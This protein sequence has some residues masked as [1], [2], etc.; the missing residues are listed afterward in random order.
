MPGDSGRGVLSPPGYSSRVR[1]PAVLPRRRGRA[2]RLVPP[3]LAGSSAGHRAEA[4][5]RCAGGRG[6]GRVALGIPQLGH[7]TCK[8]G[9]LRDEQHRRALVL[10]ARRCREGEQPGG[11]PQA[12]PRGC[13]P[14]NAPVPMAGGTGIAICRLPEN[15]AAQNAGDDVLRVSRTRAASL[16]GTSSIRSP[17]ATNYWASRCPSLPAPPPPRYAPATPPTPLASPPRAPQA[18]LGA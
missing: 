16:G 17:T 6:L 3:G 13:G 10:A 4:L 7:R 12:V 1:S 15:L 5:G 18:I 14:G 11:G 8:P 2:A 9:E